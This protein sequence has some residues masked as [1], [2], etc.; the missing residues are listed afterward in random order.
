MNKEYIETEAIKWRFDS[1]YRKIDSAYTWSYFPTIE[2]FLYHYKDLLTENNIDKDD[3]QKRVLFQ[4]KIRYNYLKSLWNLSNDELLKAY[5]I[6]YYE[7]QLSGY[8]TKEDFKQIF[9]IYEFLLK[10]ENRKNLDYNLCCAA[11]DDRPHSVCANLILYENLNLNFAQHRFRN[12]KKPD[13]KCNHTEKLPINFSGLIPYLY[14]Y[15]YIE[16]CKKAVD[17][18]Y[19]FIKHFP[20]HTLLLL[21]SLFNFSLFCGEEIYEFSN[22]RF[23]KFLLKNNKL[24]EYWKAHQKDKLSD[25]RVDSERPYIYHSEFQFNKCEIVNNEEKLIGKFYSFTLNDYIPEKYF[26]IDFLNQNIKNKNKN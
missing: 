2:S 17:I 16:E 13:F 4:R 24:R 5:N 14:L 1:D 6:C 25:V 19:D 18:A 15:G 3:L 21:I 23:L 20:E 11:W 10:K 12:I 22:K 7:T 26:D 8:P 9:E